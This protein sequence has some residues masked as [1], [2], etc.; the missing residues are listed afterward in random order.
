M[1]PKPAF[2]FVYINLG[3]GRPAL[4]FDLDCAVS[5]VIRSRMASFSVRCVPGLEA[6][7][8]GR[9][10][11]LSDLGLGW[12]TSKIGLCGMAP[13]PAFGFVCTDL[14]LSRPALGFD[15]DCAVSVVIRSRMASFSVRCVPGLEALVFGRGG[16]LSDLGLGWVTSEIGL[17]GMAPKPAF[18]F[19]RTDPSLSRPASDFDL[20][21]AISDIVRSRMA[22]FFVRN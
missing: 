13:K 19:A 22:S 2:G 14:S 15:L 10:G 11:A 7:V 21:C 4:G 3:L 9:G 5:V 20:G 1:A 17:C 16:A 8:F 18:G 6:L 12:V